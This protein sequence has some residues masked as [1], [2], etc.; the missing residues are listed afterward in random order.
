L[1]SL[2]EADKAFATK[3]YCH[4]PHPFNLFKVKPPLSCKPIYHGNKEVDRLR[5][6][7]PVEFLA[8]YSLFQAIVKICL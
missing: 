6:R 8:L 5:D 4:I 3:I 2:L 1:T 7:D